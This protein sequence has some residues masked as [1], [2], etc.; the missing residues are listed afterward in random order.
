MK[1]IIKI[2]FN[3]IILSFFL[4]S[5]IIFYSE[6]TTTFNEKISK[7]IENEL[8]NSLNLKSEIGSIKIKWQ[9]LTPSIHINNLKINNSKDK[10]L[11]EAPSS[12]IQI[13]LLQSISRNVITIKK[14]I[15][16]NT[17]VDLIHD[18][19]K[20]YFNQ[21]SITN[22][23]SRVMKR[24][25]PD[26]V[27][28]NSIINLTSI[29][30]KESTSFKVKNF[31]GTYADGSISVNA[32]FMHESSPESVTVIYRGTHND[33][34]I[35]S[36][37]F[38]SGNS[39]KLP[40]KL[41]PI[42]L[43][44][45]NSEYMSLRIWMDFIDTKIIR[46]AG[47][48]SADNLYIKLGQKFLKMTN[49]NSDLLY[50][51]N[52]ESSTLSLM[53]M[54]YTI[55]NKN[56]K[57]NKI[58]INKNNAKDLKIY[59]KKNDFKTLKKIIT[60]N[61]FENSNFIKKLLN[62]KIEN[63]QA[64]ITNTGYLDYYS[65]SLKKYSTN[66]IDKYIASNIDADVYGDL[67]KGKVSIRSLSIDTD[68]QN[69]I[70]NLSGDISFNIK[71]KSIYFN[72]SKLLNNYG[73]TISFTGKK[74]SKYPSF[75]IQI[76]S[77]INNILK[78][79]NPN[80]IK[81][82]LELGAKVVSNIYYHNNTLFSKSKIKDLYIN[83]SNKFY[84]SVNKMNIYSSSRM[85]NSDKFNLNINN[86]N[87]ISSVDTN[88]LNNSHKY[89]L[90]S[91]GDINTRV[92]K[93]II[94]DKSI[95]NGQAKFKSLLTFDSK[96]K[97]FSLYASS[98]LKGISLDI[99][100]P[101][102]KSRDEAVNFVLKYDHASIKSYPLSIILGVHKFKLK[103]DN[104]YV[105]VK[106]TSPA[107]R[108]FLKYPSKPVKNNPIHG[109][110]EYI[111]TSYFTSD[112]IG[113]SIPTINIKSKHVKVNKIVFDNVHLIMS[114]KDG[115]TEINKLDFR[116]LHLEMKSSGKWYAN[117]NEST[118][119]T[120]SINSDNF[121]KALKTLG[122]SNVIKGGELN[123][124][125][126]GKWNGSIE[127]F[128]FARTEGDLIFNINDG[129][130]NELDKGTQ[131]IGQVLGLFSI[132]S[133]PKR[134]SL[135]FSDFFSNGLRFDELKSNIKLNSGMADTKKM[136]IQGSFGEMR[137]TGESDLIKETHNQTLIFIPD[138]SST[139]LVTGAVLGGPIGAAASIF[140]DKL[141]KEFGVDTNKLAGIEYS[142]KGPWKNPEIRVTKSFKPI[143][144]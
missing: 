91:M 79:I 119:L 27:L 116:N 31:I 106:V 18:N 114:P 44:Q 61:H 122:Y 111:D 130:I 123:A 46:V 1:N 26:I 141:L 16:N 86:K 48:I 68:S 32:N 112:E 120:A 51:K 55:D 121:G 76:S 52:K 73:H 131:T 15:I 101:F 10:T 113:S 118:Q 82:D 104:Q 72:S 143:T 47:N 117:K 85:L 109:S 13:N 124:K 37:L 132:S 98:N 89:L 6:H 2:F 142:I 11:L 38:I 33:N 58:V 30:N 105:Y 97:K 92:F 8:Y 84:L 41:L 110:F 59:I 3:I 66:L 137:L 56:I 35:H 17:S 81:D 20:I 69:L 108:G 25:I 57:N 4:S 5:L 70:S 62:S 93:D 71:G 102:R 134:L 14:I 28:N 78:T 67:K 133:I 53:R 126:N 75:K 87:L 139:S 54:N 77:S 42:S 74:V 21:K 64:H 136:I 88:I 103:I 95:A 96:N 65:F 127:D 43:R 49:V 23:S 29:K 80:V 60:M 7:S 24:T 99:M 22:K 12:E 19:S 135:D 9:G 144:N 140:Y 45:I 50:L 107:V 34:A 138:L 39:I 94:F 115:Y 36:K 83:K 100:E 128:S 63:F 40:Y 90:T 125:L 129:Q